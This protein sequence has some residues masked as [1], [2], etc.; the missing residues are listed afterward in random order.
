[1]NDEKRAIKILQE[2]YPDKKYVMLPAVNKY[3]I[4]AIRE[5]GEPNSSFHVRPGDFGGLIYN[6]DNLSQEGNCWVTVGVT[7]DGNARVSDNA[8]IGVDIPKKEYDNY[9]VVTHDAKVKDSVIISYDNEK[10]GKVI[11]KDSAVI[12]GTASIYSAKAET[13]VS[14]NANIRGNAFIGG[15]QVKG[16]AIVK[17]DASI[18]GENIIVRNYALICDNAKVT[19]KNFEVR[20]NSIIS[21]NAKIFNSKSLFEGIEKY[22]TNI[23]GYC[24]ITGNAVVAN[25]IVCNHATI[26]GGTVEDS[27]ISGRSTVQDVAYVNNC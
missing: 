22:D 20:G 25:S 7:V 26:S 4:M 6:E 15:V 13:I 21:G 1:M 3:R 18:T 24:K 11:I 14:E 2:K 10:D 5:F 17:D 12:E 23:S 19:G 27:Y 8:W 16:H 9:I